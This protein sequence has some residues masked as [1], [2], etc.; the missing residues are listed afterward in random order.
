MSEEIRNK[1][2][3][4]DFEEELA[5]EFNSLNYEKSG[6]VFPIIPGNVG[7]PLTDGKK[8]DG[9]RCGRHSGTPKERQWK[10]IRDF[11]QHHRMRT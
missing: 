1:R 10:T 5:L 11:P 7:K 8:S 4:I 6:N 2:N 9:R 3:H